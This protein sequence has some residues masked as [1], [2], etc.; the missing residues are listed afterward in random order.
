MRA[1]QGIGRHSKD[2][3]VPEMEQW[4]FK[5]QR[6]RSSHVAGSCTVEC[7]PS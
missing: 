1:N 4:L 2:G 6:G 3:S 7:S 5:G